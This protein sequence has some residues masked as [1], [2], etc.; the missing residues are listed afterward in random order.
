MVILPRM[1]DHAA[2]MRKTASPLEGRSQQV[3]RRPHQET[4]DAYPPLFQ[5][6]VP[7]PRGLRPLRGRCGRR[8]RA[9]RG[10]A[11]CLG[12]DQAG[13]VRRAGR[14][15]RRCRPDGAA[16][17]G[18]HR[19]AQADEGVD[20]RRQQVRRRRRR[21]LPRRQGCQGRPAQDHHHA[22]QPVHHAAGHR[23]ALQLEGHDAGVDD[24]ARPVRAVG[25]RRDRP[26]RRPPSTS[27]P[28]RPPARTR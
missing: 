19:Q 10:R 20:G 24:G 6:P 9:V 16:D 23:R 12:A 25:Q 8:V 28:S 15:R 26:T 27:P 22:V 5:A 2:A 7:P 1:L 18:H 14:H 4:T 3:L 11:G 13:R 17:P 21:G